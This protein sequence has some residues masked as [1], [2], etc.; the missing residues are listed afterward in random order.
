MQVKA[1]R[2]EIE[3]VILDIKSKVDDAAKKLE[4]KKSKL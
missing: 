2:G 4:E 3:D 1:D